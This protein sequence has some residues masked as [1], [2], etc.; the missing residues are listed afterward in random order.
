M[1]IGLAFPELGVH[2]IEHFLNIFKNY[3]SKLDLIIFPE[4]FESIATRRQ[5]N[6]ENILNDTN[7]NAIVTKY[8][9]ISNNNGIGI[10][11]G[12]QVDYG[13][14]TVNGKGND[15]YCIFLAKNIRPVLYHKHSTSR[16]NAFLDNNW[17]IQ[18]NFPVVELNN[19]KIGISI[20]HDSYISIIQRV[21]QKKGAQIWVNI[22]YRNVRPRIWESVM[23]TRSIENN[24]ISICTLHR[25]STKSNAQSEPY[26]FSERGKIILRNIENNNNIKDI[27]FNER[28]GKIYYLDTEQFLVSHL[29]NPTESTLAESAKQI[30]INRDN[31]QF[32]V[33]DL[34]NMELNSYH[35]ADVSVSEFFYNPEVLWQT[36]AKNLDGK[37]LFVIKL[38][39]DEWNVNRNKILSIIRGRI[40][41]FSTLF[42]FVDSAN[43][44]HIFLAGYRSSNYKD[45]RIFF[46]EYFPITIDERYL[47]GLE[48]T[49]DIS[50]KDPRMNNKNQYFK[51]IL[52]TLNY[53]L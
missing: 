40:I 23:Q 24:I 50:L 42:L 39:Q 52:Q 18:N 37:P 33:T 46:P 36:S 44:N 19:K 29:E 5:I 25:D 21:L 4:G 47:K 3:N 16:F 15:Q 17:S 14:V 27:N 45:S 48:S 12:I 6:P 43:L 11:L 10:I 22:S 49:Y 34:Q 9:D 28:T 2:R 13:N 38:N 20:C 53:I 41:E 1:R 31:M 30:L 51:K 8:S 7:F 35:I 26:A 32:H